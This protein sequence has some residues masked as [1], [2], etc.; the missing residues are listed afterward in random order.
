MRQK[1]GSPLSDVQTEKE[2]NHTGTQDSH[3]GSVAMVAMPLAAMPDM[4]SHFGLAG[5][6]GLP[7][8]A[9]ASAFAE[10]SNE[11]RVVERWFEPSRQACWPK[12][13]IRLQTETWLGPPFQRSSVRSSLAP[14]FGAFEM[15]FIAQARDHMRRIQAALGEFLQKEA[16]GERAGSLNALRTVPITSRAT[17]PDWHA[18]RPTGRE[19]ADSER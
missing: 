16:L 19:T 17:Y 11:N 15:H 5:G 10:C 4:T 7:V 2:T 3:A 8:K 13:G 9:S 6:T 18:G 12:T 14:K 1:S